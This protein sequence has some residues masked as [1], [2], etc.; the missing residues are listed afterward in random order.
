M[1][2]EKARR[3]RVN[4][5]IY[6]LGQR[7][8]VREVDSAGTPTYV[9]F[10]SISS[11]LAT[12]PGTLVSAES[13]ADFSSARAHINVNN[14]R[15]RTGGPNPFPDISDVPCPEAARQ[16]LWYVVIPFDGLLKF[17]EDSNVQYGSEGLRSPDLV[18]GVDGFRN[19]NGGLHEVSFVQRRIQVSLAARADFGSDGTEMIDSGSVRL[20]SLGCMEWPEK[21]ASS[22]G[23]ANAD[24]RVEFL[25]LGQELVGD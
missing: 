22:Q 17:I 6:S 21:G 4:G 15:V 23:V 19:G 25:K 24:G 10:P 18:R 12:P 13:G 11:R 3:S 16:T 20:N 1:F 2:Q 9:L 7:S 8:G 5:E 14:A